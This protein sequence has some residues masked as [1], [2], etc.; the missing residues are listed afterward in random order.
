MAKTRKEN[1]EDLYG[2]FCG[3]MTRGTMDEL[4]GQLLGAVPDLGSLKGSIE[5]LSPSGTN[6]SDRMLG[7]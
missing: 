4:Y 5:L 1:F 6:T 3:M 2:Y 7:S